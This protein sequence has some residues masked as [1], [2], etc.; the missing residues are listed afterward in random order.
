METTDRNFAS[1]KF[2]ITPVFRTLA[3]HDPILPS[4]FYLFS[5]QRFIIFQSSFFL[6]SVASTLILS[7]IG[8]CP[9]FHPCMSEVF[10]VACWANLFGELLVSFF[11]CVLCRWPWGAEKSLFLSKWSHSIRLARNI[12]EFFRVAWK[13][14]NT[15]W[16]LGVLYVVLEHFPCDA[17]LAS[18][19]FCMSSSL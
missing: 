3:F 17:C 11:A 9:F 8:V 6:N 13:F 5:K 2:F 4:F 12:I 15:L 19:F 7:A 16:S 18:G 10:A 14:G 1:F